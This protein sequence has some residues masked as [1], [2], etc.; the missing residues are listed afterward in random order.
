[1]DAVTHWDAICRVFGKTMKTTGF[2]AMATVNPDG[3]PHIAPIGSLIL[4][5]PGQACYFEKFPVTMR[6]NL[7]RDPRVCVLAAYGGF[8]GTL[9]ALFRGRFASA[10]GVRRSGVAGELRPATEAEERTWRERIKIFRRLKGYDL[11]WK[12]MTQVRDIRFDSFEPVRIGL[13]TRGLWSDA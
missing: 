5:A 10:P 3:S 4:H 11:L 1:M 9:A 7:D 12:D 8:L 6:R 13:M 2:C